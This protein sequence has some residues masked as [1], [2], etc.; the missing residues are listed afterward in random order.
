MK[1][2]K[3]F[4]PN[5]KNLD[6]KLKELECGKKQA[7]NMFSLSCLPEKIN[8]YDLRTDFEEI[9]ANYWDW[10]F[11]KHISNYLLKAGQI[12]YKAPSSNVYTSIYLL[13]FK[14]GIDLNKL[15]RK[16]KLEKEINQAK[17]MQTK[18]LK[19]DNYLIAIKTN[20][21]DKCSLDIFKNWY[22]NNFK[23]EAL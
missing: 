6:K 4:L 18:C 14:N 20:H 7:N 15:N 10:H 22:L 11:G 2:P 23:L 13:E 5:N 16:I 1:T 17:N 19:K 12:T 9:T 3:T 21:I 8:N